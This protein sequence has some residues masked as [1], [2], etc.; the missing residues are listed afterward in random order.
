M[1]RLLFIFMWLIWSNL[2]EMFHVV[3]GDVLV[4]GFG[5][6]RE[7]GCDHEG[8]HLYFEIALSYRGTW[9]STV[10]FSLKNSTVVYCEPTNCLFVGKRLFLYVD[11]IILIVN[12]IRVINWA[13]VSVKFTIMEKTEAFLVEVSALNRVLFFILSISYP[14]CIHTSNGNR[15]TS[16]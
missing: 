14:Y 11:P 2:F 3:L 10:T 9:N 6:R 16:L 5:L 15:F 1:Y 8:R 7:K 13:R 4:P 12:N